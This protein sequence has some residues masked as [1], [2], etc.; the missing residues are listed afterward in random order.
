MTTARMETVEYAPGRSLDVLGRPDGGI[1]LLW[2]GRG[3][4]HR[5][6]MHPLAERIAARGVLALA[7]DWSSEAPDGGRTDLL[8]A[9]RF[10]RDAAEQHG[11]HPDSVVI[12]GWS[13]GGTAALS[14]AVHSG[15]LGG[16]LGGV[17]LIAPGDG[18]RVSDPF[19]GQP[20]PARFPPGA[21]RCAVDLVYGADD[22]L[23][24]PDLVSGLELRLRSS[25]WST[26]MHAV[27][28][29]H[30]EIV[31]TRYA[32]RVE[33][34]LPSPTHRATTAADAVADVIVAAATSSSR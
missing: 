11:H 2:H 16:E 8:G 32:A 27:Q 28:A 7:A 3:I 19:N 9:W 26:S 31:G 13:L 14:L 10:A 34:Y 30:A 6:S 20:L 21:G 24:T 4:D 12:A 22:P 23:S 29:D 15:S 25:G 18:P 1:A 5:G 17:V 33:R